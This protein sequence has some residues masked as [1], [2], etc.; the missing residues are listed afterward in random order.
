MC[1][2]KGHLPACRRLVAVL[3]GEV[4]RN[5]GDQFRYGLVIRPVQRPRIEKMGSIAG[6]ADDARFGAVLD[7]ADQRVFLIV[8]PLF[9]PVELI[10][11]LHREAEDTDLKAGVLLEVFGDHG[12]WI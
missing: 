10:F 4:F 1:S 7:V 8:L 9:G 11:H 6:L 3:D 2:E 12:V 5:A